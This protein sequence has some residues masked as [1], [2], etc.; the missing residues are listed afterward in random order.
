MNATGCCCT[1][2]LLWLL[3]LLLPLPLLVEQLEPVAVAMADGSGA[4][5]VADA[6]ADVVVV[7]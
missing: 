7:E 4:I 3:L 2:A 5:T 1:A 6:V